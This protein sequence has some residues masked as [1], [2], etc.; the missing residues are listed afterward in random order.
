VPFLKK[1]A[2]SDDKIKT[3]RNIIKQETGKILVTEQIPSLLIND[4]KIKDPEMVSDVF[5]NL[6][7][8]IAENLKL[9][10]VGKKD[11]IYF[12]QRCISSQIPWY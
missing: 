4:E 8:S 12:F 9:H 5:N 7:L 10:Q 6:F 1:I 2:K 11:R 3:T